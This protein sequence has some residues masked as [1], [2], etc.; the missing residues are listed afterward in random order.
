MFSSNLRHTI[1][2]GVACPHLSEPA[3]RSSGISESMIC[4]GDCGLGYQC[5]TTGTIAGIG[6]TS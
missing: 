5:Q 6:L 2:R 3:H 4:L 1:N